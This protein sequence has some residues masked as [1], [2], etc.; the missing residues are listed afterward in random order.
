MNSTTTAVAG[1]APA[2]KLDAAN[3]ISLA[4]LSSRNSDRNAL[5]SAA[6]A[7][8][9]PGCS[10][11]SIAACLHQPRKVSGLTP[12]RGPIRSTACVS[13]KPGSCARAS[14]TSRCARSRSSLG[15]FL[16]AGSLLQIARGAA[17]VRWPS[18]RIGAW[19][20]TFAGLTVTSAFC[21]LQICGSG[22]LLS[23]WSGS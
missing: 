15:Y 14:A 22:Y 23:I 6:S 9:T 2:K 12:T 3:R 7:V 13:D 17:A 16:G 19:R 20:S 8:L 1:R 18:L 10:P 5:I 4:R 21:C 11:A